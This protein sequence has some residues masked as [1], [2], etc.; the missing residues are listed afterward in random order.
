MASPELK[1]E[2]RLNVIP[3]REKICTLAH[4]SSFQGP[5]WHETLTRSD[6]KV[7]KE[8]IKALFNGKKITEDKC[9][10]CHH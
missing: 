5:V 7:H 3:E 2:S 1:L 8:K 6:S 9:R 4:Q 10:I